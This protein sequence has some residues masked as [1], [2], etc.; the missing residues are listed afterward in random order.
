MRHLSANILAREK[1]LYKGHP[2]AAVAADNVHIATEA[3]KLIK[4][5]YEALRPVL[6][7]REAMRD[8]APILNDDIRTQSIG[9]HPDAKNGSKPTNIAKHF[10]FE[11]G[12]IAKGFAS[13]DVVI[14]R[15]FDT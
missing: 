13:A 7:V 10:W 3:V 14:E 4:V 9:S 2:V 1:V 5:D 6:D 15:E 11:K 8:D 12:D